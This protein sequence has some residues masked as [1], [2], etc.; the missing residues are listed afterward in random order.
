MRSG[1]GRFTNR[2]AIRTVL[3]IIGILW[4]VLLLTLVI[5]SIKYLGIRPRTLIGLAGI[6]AAPLI[7]D[8]IIHC[9]A[10]TMGIL[11]LGF[12]FA[13][14]EKQ[15]AGYILIPIYLLSGLGPWVFGAANSIHI[16]ASGV[17][18]GLLGYLLTIGFFRRHFKT[19]LLSILV[20]VLYGGALWGIFPSYGRFP[21]SWE[22]H[23]SGFLAGVLV[24]WSE[25]NRRQ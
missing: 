12:L 1:K 11:V 16:G 7:H 6:L 22:G 4:L 17:I 18:Y 3:A 14:L 2:Q 20:L 24:A 13:G 23:L 21:I 25:G 9:A 19:I 10:N 5:P 8:G 15:R